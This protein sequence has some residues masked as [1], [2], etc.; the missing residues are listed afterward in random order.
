MAKE[1]RTTV[2]NPT[3]IVD[4]AEDLLSNRCGGSQELHD[5][6]QLTG[7]G[8]ATVLRARVAPSPFLQQRSV[9]LKYIPETGDKLDDAAL[10]REV[11][12]YQFT[13]SL[14]EEVRP[15]PV[16]L[17]H[18]IAK[19][20][21]VLTDSGDGDTFDDLL[22]HRGTEERREILRN[23]GSSL[24]RMH[25]ATAGKE[26]AFETLL[27]RLL[28]NHPEIAELHEQRD[29]S[30]G[31]AVTAGVEILEA[32]GISV[33]REVRTLADESNT[34]LTVGRARAFTPF[35]LSPDNIIVSDKTHF[36]DYEW[37][38]FRDV[39]FDIACVIAGFPQFV[40]TRPITDDEAVIFI[41]SWVEEV[42]D[43]WPNARNEDMLHSRITIA[44]IGWAMSSLSLMRYG[45]LSGVVAQTA[46]A[47]DAQKAEEYPSLLRPASEAPF[48]QDELLVR[49]DFY[50]TF[51]ALQRFAAAGRAPEH[52]VVAAFA[53]E[54]AARVAEPGLK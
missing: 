40:S 11:A 5:V 10:L 7:S 32:G 22:R 17:A 27:A 42:S 51:E 2:L 14:S 8:A 41:E 29:E 31:F 1:S 35:D 6:E 37:A 38:A 24:G 9:V 43:I 39:A 16:L 15:G 33:P 30:L 49:R 44:L 53:A 4:V 46:R 21:I 50:E 48:T 19:R 47:V 3:E 23:L 13:N 54:V 26:Q 52:P 25:A 34:R 36:L 12:A 28:R 18:D 45:S 20:I